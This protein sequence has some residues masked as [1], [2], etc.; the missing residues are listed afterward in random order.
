MDSNQLRRD[1]R[2]RDSKTNFSSRDRNR[3]PDRRDISRD[4]SYE[5]R[6]AQYQ[7][8]VLAKQFP[9]MKRSYNCRASYNPITTKA[10]SKCPMSSGHHEFSCT[11]YQ[12]YNH[13][14]CTACEKYN[15]FPSDCKE[16]PKYPPTHS[17]SQSIQINP[18]ET[19]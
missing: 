5:A 13:R 1:S 19:N 2:D 12:R 10:C 11:K 18:D 8:E 3:T 9:E 15:H 16:I 4:R 14:I 6:R 17:D 7:E